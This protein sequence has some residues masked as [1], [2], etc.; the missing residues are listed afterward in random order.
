MIHHCP[1]DRAVLVH[2]ALNNK[3]YCPKC[4]LHRTRLEIAFVKGGLYERDGEGRATEAGEAQGG[5]SPNV[6]E[7]QGQIQR[8]PTS[9]TEGA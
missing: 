5:T 6:G 9:E 8:T 1:T 2:F 4:K 7:A 3:F